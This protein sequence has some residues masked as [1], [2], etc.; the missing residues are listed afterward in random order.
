VL[1]RS[2]GTEVEQKEAF[3][4]IDVEYIDL[5]GQ[6]ESGDYENIKNIIALGTRI[7]H[8]ELLLFINKQCILEFDNPWMPS[9]VD[10]KKYGYNLTWDKSI[11]D[12]IN[13][14]ENIESSEKV[15]IVELE[16]AKKKLKKPDENEETRTYKRAD[17]IKMII[18]LQKQKY[19]IDRDR[20]TM[21]ELA[22]MVGEVR[23]QILANDLT[24][25]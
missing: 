7:K 6:Y 21:E 23:D 22:I 2:E 5:S 15:H 25:E 16:I 3:S 24:P 4:K 1:F 19:I 20:T 12:F 8:I 18:N 10:F 14:L 9:L 11:A 17:F 13:Q